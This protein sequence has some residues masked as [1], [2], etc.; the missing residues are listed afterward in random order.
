MRLIAL[1]DVASNCGAIPQGR[2]FVCLDD[3]LAQRLI[4]TGQAEA[5]PVLPEG[6]KWNGLD[7]R[8]DTVVIL[9]S[10]PSL[11]RA[12]VEQVLI[13]SREFDAEDF[14]EIDPEDL[15]IV[16]ATRAR[17]ANRRVIAINTTYQ[18]APWADVLYACDDTWWHEYH[19][20]MDGVTCEKWTQ[21]EPSAKKYGLKFIRSQASN[22]LSRTPGLIYQG[23]SSGYQAIGLAH[24]AGAKRI[25]LLGFD[26][27]GTHWHGNHPKGLNKRLPFADWIPR[28]EALAKDLKADGVE[29][30]NCTPGSAITAFPMM[31]LDEA[32]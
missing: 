28:F 24:Q 30:I 5:E 13:W 18:M 6:R 11:D 26:C 19:D 14:K 29:V 25:I 9:A 4:R 31:S 32:L 21:D 22:G 7:W 1:Q 23:K 17:I 2:T 16:A 10:G 12:Q 15:A 27:H 3:D 20:K 8:G